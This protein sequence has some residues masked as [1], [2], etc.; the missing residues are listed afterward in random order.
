MLG[1]LRTLKSRKFLPAYLL[2]AEVVPFYLRM[3]AFLRNAA[4]AAAIAVLCAAA[5][6]GQA[7]QA[8]Q[9]AKATLDYS[10]TLF[11]VLAVMNACGYDAELNSSEPLRAA[12]R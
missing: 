5:A 1:H 3:V 6:L 2:E 8:Q 12:V 9:T 11:S 10:E 4:R 7:L